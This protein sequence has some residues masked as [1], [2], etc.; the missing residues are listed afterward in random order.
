MCAFWYIFRHNSCV[1]GYNILVHGRSLDNNILFHLVTDFKFI[2]GHQLIRKKRF[3]PKVYFYDVFTA[4]SY[5]IFDQF[6]IETLE[7]G[8]KHHKYILQ[9]LSNIITPLQKCEL[10]F[11]IDCVRHFVTIF[12]VRYNDPVKWLIN[13]LFWLKTKL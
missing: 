3:S 6:L 10:F 9:K 5:M 13:H 12:G 2:Y 1:C 11:G 7:E 8:S 4:F